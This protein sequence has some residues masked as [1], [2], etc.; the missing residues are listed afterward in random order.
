ME[1]KNFNKDAWLKKLL[2]NDNAEDRQRMYLNINL[3]RQFKE[4]LFEKMTE[5]E[6]GCIN[7][8]H[9][10]NYLIERALDPTTEE[11]YKGNK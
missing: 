8:Y 1:N 4:Y 5:K 3:L 11:I 2:Y 6:K 7:L 10:E 9:L